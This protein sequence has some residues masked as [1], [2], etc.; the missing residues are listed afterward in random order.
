MLLRQGAVLRGM[1]VMM[2][3]QVGC[4]I[5]LWVCAA[6]GAGMDLRMQWGTF[7]F[8]VVWR[9][10][11]VTLVNTT[12]PL[13]IP[14][15]YLNTAIGT[16]FTVSGIVSTLLQHPLSQAIKD[17]VKSMWYIHTISCGLIVFAWI[18]WGTIACNCLDPRSGMSAAVAREACQ[19]HEVRQDPEM[20]L[21]QNCA[22]TQK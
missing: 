19:D 17:D 20:S 2:A 13:V 15:A 4:G 11:S 6:T 22:R 9:M 10:N 1:M 3:V 12:L 5:G 7:I 16:I 8:F 18:S 21:V 14:R